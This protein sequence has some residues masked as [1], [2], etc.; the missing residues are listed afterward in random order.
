LERVYGKER[1]NGGTMPDG[2]LNLAVVKVTTANRGKKGFRKSE[3]N[4]T[5]ATV[6]AKDRK[7]NHTPVP[8]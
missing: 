3:H 6:K 7:G 8:S 5:R 2:K 1:K 4:E